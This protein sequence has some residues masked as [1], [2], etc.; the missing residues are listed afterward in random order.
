MSIRIAATT[1]LVLG[2]LAH[3]TLIG[4][5]AVVGRVV[6]T[7]GQLLPG[8]RA[9]VRTAIADA[10]LRIRAICECVTVG[11][12][13]PTIVRSGRIVNAEGQPLPR[14]RLEIVLPLPASPVDVAGRPGT[15]REVAYTDEDG[16]FSILAPIGATWPVTASDSGFPPR[17]QQI[18]GSRT[19]PLLFT[20]LYAG[21]PPGVGAPEYELLS[22]DDCSCQG[23]LFTER[24]R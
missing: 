2:V 24:P 17:T 10:T 3:T 21:G 6:D 7:A 8:V 9:N 22:T 4:Q 15:W 11:G 13:P 16:R 19:E 12:L 20:L 14:A 23:N 5:S 18:S 1:V